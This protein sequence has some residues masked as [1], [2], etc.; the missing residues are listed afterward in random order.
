MIPIDQGGG[1]YTLLS[2]I[3][4]SPPTRAKSSSAASQKYFFRSKS[5]GQSKSLQY[6]GDLASLYVLWRLCS[7]CLSLFVVKGVFSVISFPVPHKQGGTH[8]FLAP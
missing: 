7:P 4:A 5:T 1:G 2:Q 8:D 3:G 6:R